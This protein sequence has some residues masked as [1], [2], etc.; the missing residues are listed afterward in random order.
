ML[1]VA[2]LPATASF[3]KARTL[4]EFDSAALHSTALTLPCTGY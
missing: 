2:Q 4:C 1:A 3:K